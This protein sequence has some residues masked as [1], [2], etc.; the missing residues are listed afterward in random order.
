MPPNCF[1]KSVRVLT[2]SLVGQS[3]RVSC[4]LFWLFFGG[5]AILKEEEEEE[6]ALNA[7]PEQGPFSSGKRQLEKQSAT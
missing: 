7:V 4:S 1:L 6:E 5:A 3:S 2:I